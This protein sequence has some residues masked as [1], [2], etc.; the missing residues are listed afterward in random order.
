MSDGA[1]TAAGKKQEEP[2]TSGRFTAIADSVQVRYALS[3]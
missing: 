2:Q 1:Q 3:L